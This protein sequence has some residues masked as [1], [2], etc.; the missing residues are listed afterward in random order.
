M[1]S[2]HPEQPHYLCSLHGCCLALSPRSCPTCF[3]TVHPP[4]IS[5]FPL[6]KYVAGAEGRQI[7]LFQYACH[8]LLTT[9]PGLGVVTHLPATLHLSDCVD[10]DQLTSSPSDTSSFTPLP[11]QPLTP[12]LSHTLSPTLHPHPS[13]S[14]P[15]LHTHSIL[16]TI[17]T[18]GIQC[19]IL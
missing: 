1:G 8:A 11:H 13:H 5:P 17:Y 14:S 7:Y 6:L 19:K 16:T 4:W 10:G 18:P 15:H 12:T 3:Q 9:P 2:P